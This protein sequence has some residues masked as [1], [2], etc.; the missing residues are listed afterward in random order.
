MAT[1]SVR[2]W[3]WDWP[4][5]DAGK[6]VQMVLADRVPS[7]FRHLE[8]ADRIAAAFEPGF[9]TFV[10]VDC[11][12]FKRTGKLLAA[13]PPARHQHRSS[14]HQRDV[15]HAEPDRRGGGGHLRHPDQLSALLGLS[16]HQADRCRAADRHHHRH[17][18]FPDLQCHARG[19]APGRHAD[20]DGRRYA[21]SLHARVWCVAPTPRP[22]TGE[23]GSPAWNA[24]M[25]WSSEL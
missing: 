21:G 6:R 16:D 8:G 15:R 1:R 20:G 23:A 11:A 7:A 5:E 25:A 4:C 17:P 9:D 13:L 3:A 18:G 10:T 2:C 14:H 22:A 24:R 12:D 19:D